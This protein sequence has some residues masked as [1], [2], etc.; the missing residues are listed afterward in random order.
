MRRTRFSGPIF[1][2]DARA[3]I[4]IFGQAPGNI[5]HGKDLPFSDPSGARLRDW[6]GVD[7]ATFY[8]P[9]TFLIAPMAFC[10]PGY[11]KNG[12]DAPPPKICAA[13]WRQRLMAALPALRLKLLVGAYAQGWHLGKE[14]GGSLTETVARWRDY[15]PDHLPLPHPSWRNN[16][17]LKKNPWFEKELLPELRARVRSAIG[18]PSGA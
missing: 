4:A 18:K 3:R 6:L 9:A 17:W 2:I 1:Q 16:G 7:E 5:A 8:D 15:G 11:D 13:H 10:F 14:A 12:G